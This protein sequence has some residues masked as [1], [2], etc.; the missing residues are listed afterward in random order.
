MTAADPSDSAQPPHG[1]FEYG[2]R[3]RDGQLW[4]RGGQ[5]S[6]PSEPV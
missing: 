3:I 5:L 4:V 2:Y 6:R 1:L